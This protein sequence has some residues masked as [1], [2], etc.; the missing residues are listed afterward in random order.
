MIPS[1]LLLLS[2][3]I[4]L[5]D[6]VGSAL[7]RYGEVGSYRMTLRS[8]SGDNGEVIRYYYKRP[9]FIRMEFVTP[10][11][12]A[13]LVYDPVAK[14]VRIRPLAFIPAFVLTLSPDNSLVKSAQGHRVDESDIGAL[15]QRVRRLQERG[16]TIVQREERVGGKESVVVAVEGEKGRALEGIHRYVLWLD[17]STL[18]PLKSAAYDSKGTQVEE[19]LMDD[20]EVNV[21]LS[22][23]LFK[24]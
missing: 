14:T 15:L 3:V 24:L 6:P 11:K 19:V 1:I 21:E 12:G 2:L 18:L 4:P 20:L 10:H 17:R 7:E 5:T 9:G 13:V 23:S 16:T 22:D 8:G